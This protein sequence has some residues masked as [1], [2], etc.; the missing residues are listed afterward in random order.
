[1]GSYIHL[2]V[3]SFQILASPRSIKFFDECGQFFA[4]L[5]A[6]SPAIRKT[7]EDLG[8]KFKA[9]RTSFVKT[10]KMDRRGVLR[11]SRMGFSMG[12]GNPVCPFLSMTLSLSSYRFMLFLF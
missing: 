5:A 10:Q 11:H 3:S 8:P 7:A 9:T 1:M 2:V 12:M 6:G 4:L